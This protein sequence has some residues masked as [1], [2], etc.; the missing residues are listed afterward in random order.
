MHRVKQYNSW[1][2]CFVLGSLGCVNTVPQ[3][4]TEQTRARSVVL[5]CNVRLSRASFTAQV[6]N[7]SVC[8]YRYALCNTG[9]HH[10]LRLSENLID[11]LRDSRENKH[12]FKS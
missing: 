4:I 3:S 7:S 2:A 11:A 12:E 1:L 9:D 6:Y 5:C 8:R 10:Y